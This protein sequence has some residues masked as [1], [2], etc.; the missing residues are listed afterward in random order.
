MDCRKTA[1]ALSKFGKELTCNVFSSLDGRSI[2]VQNRVYIPSI[3]HDALSG[4]R[5]SFAF[6]FA[7]AASRTLILRR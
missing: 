2:N 5:E 7:S 4:T 1:Q 6:F 3:I